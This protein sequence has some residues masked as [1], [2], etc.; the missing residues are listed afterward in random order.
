MTDVSNIQERWHPPMRDT[1]ADRLDKLQA[2]AQANVD[3]RIKRNAQYSVGLQDDSFASY[4]VG[5]QMA[6]DIT[7]EEADE[8]VANMA[9]TTKSFAKGAALGPVTMAPDL[10][11]GL[12]K[13]LNATTDYA[14]HYIYGDDRGALDA[15]VISGDPIRQFAGLEPDDIAGI[16]GESM[17][18][19]ENA[20]AKGGKFAMAAW[21][22]MM[23]VDPQLT[24]GM[25]MGARAA[26]NLG[27][28]QRIGNLADAEAMLAQGG[29]PATVFADTGWYK[30][31]ADDQMKFVVSDK[32]SVVRSD[33]LRE[34]IETANMDIGQRKRITYKMSDIFEHPT[35]YE[36][37]P[38]LRDMPL[39]LHIT[40]SADDANGDTVYRLYDAEKA[41]SQQFGQAERTR[42]GP[43][44]SIFN[45]KDGDLGRGTIL[46]EIQHVIQ[47][48][49][50]FSGGASPAKF[51]ALTDAY[52]E[53]R[54]QLRIMQDAADG[55]VD[56][57]APSENQLQYL[58]DLQADIGMDTANPEK[59]LEH[60]TEV[61]ID[62]AKK[63]EFA[64]YG[65][66]SDDQ[67]WEAEMLVESLK[68]EATRALYVGDQQA[69]A[70][71]LESGTSDDLWQAAF[72]R[73]EVQGGEVEARITEFL[74]NKSQ[75]EIE[76][77]LQVRGQTPEGL[78]DVIKTPLKEGEVVQP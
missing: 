23:H 55:V 18:G 15:P 25:I 73:Y 51:R 32:D 14:S 45:D 49:E 28:T 24:L 10:V 3:K 5:K 71:L 37:Y 35:I 40:R 63:D 2:Q 68:D 58:F 60:L 62:V 21:D 53:A 64:K 43:R 27:D 26:E 1:V 42:Q 6:G 74:K 11:G 8:M 31:A 61:L 66:Y 33:Y 4:V 72:R 54:L 77:L 75:R 34:D 69:V 57:D 52:D 59:Q 38:Q 19:W 16:V 78:T 13:F 22:S 30:G 46:H 48:I 39:T 9:E 70:D 17:G 41:A 50:G 29:N 67:L 20:V 7:A 47:D 36:A 12:T 76:A 65:G 56:F 44:V